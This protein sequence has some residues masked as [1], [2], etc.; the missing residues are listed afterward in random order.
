MYVEVVSVNPQIASNE[1]ISG[2]IGDGLFPFVS[3]IQWI[4]QVD[5][6]GHPTDISL[7]KF[8]QPLVPTG[9]AALKRPC[10]A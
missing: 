5:L 3:H 7:P 4:T 1:A 8:A 9:G 6:W 2:K 10:W